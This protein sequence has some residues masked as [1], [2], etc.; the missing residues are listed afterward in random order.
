MRQ[1]IFLAFPFLLFTLTACQ[2]TEGNEPPAAEVAQAS[3]TALAVES[4]V[5]AIATATQTFLPVLVETIVTPTATP[6]PSPTAMPTAT[7]SPTPQT[8]PVDAISLEPILTEGLL[9]PVYLTHAF[10]GR[11]FIVEQD[12]TIRIIQEGQLLPEAFLDISERVGSNGYEQGLLSVA[13][14]PDYATAGQPGTGVFY[15]YYTDNNGDTVV[16]HFQVS[17]SSPN[18][19]DENSEVIV[20]QVDQ[21]YPNH[22]GGLLKFGP[23]DYLYVGLGDGG[24]AGDPQ[25]HGQNK[26]TLLGSMLRIDV[27]Q[28]GD[29]YEIP[30]DN[31][32]VDDPDA[33]PEIWSYGWR[34][35]WRF[36]FD[37][38]T[39]DM[40]IADVGQGMWEEVSFQPGNSQGGE[41][42]GWN[43]MEANACF[44]AQS[45]DQSG[46]V[47]PIFDYDHSKGCS[48]TGGYV[49]RGEQFPELAGN[50]FVADFCSGIMWRLFPDGT[51]HWLEAEFPSSGFPVSSFGED[52]NGELYVL[53][54]SGGVY[55]IWPAGQ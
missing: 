7:P 31:P 16:S 42:Y 50:Y 51:G 47:L 32:F 5:Q 10:D 1:K 44:S 38:L 39:G 11:L 20:L 22:N 28:A 37:R 41:N 27:S 13:F 45:C 48:I 3:A 36:S 17:E 23:D 49:Y 53:D 35:P 43:I 25:G 33:R 55:Q 26:D 15:V 8:T 29:G 40:Y 18:L 6:V 46:L 54:H 19:A 21:P 52:V 30:P 9:R 12:G 14:H 4:P 34:N 2:P 24:S